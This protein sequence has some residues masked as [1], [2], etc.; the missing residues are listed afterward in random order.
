MPSS[1]SSPQPNLQAKDGELRFSPQ[2][3]LLLV[4]TGAGA[5][6]A[7]GVLMR[8][9]HFV[10]H[11]AWP[12]GSGNLLEGAERSP[13]GRH[14]IV[15]L[16][17]GVVAGIGLRILASVFRGKSSDLE[18]AIWFHWGKLPLVQTLARAL[19]SIVIVGMGASLGRESALKQVGAAIGSWLSGRLRPSPAQTRLLAACGAGAGMAAAYNMPC[20][21]ALFALEILLGELSLPLALPALLASA[22]A[23][24]VSSFFLA[25]QPTYPIP[26]Y[27]FAISQVAWALVAGPLLGLAAA[28]FVRVIS[29]AESHKPRGWGVAAAPVVVL[30]VL[31]SLS[32]P[33]PHLLGNGM[34]TVELAFTDQVGFELLLIL[35]LLKLLAT[36]SCLASGIP[37]GLFTPVLMY[38]SLLGGLLGYGYRLFWPEAPL[39]SYAILGAGAV[40]AASTQAPLSAV[41]MLTEL[42]WRLDPLM[43]PLIISVG[44]ATLVARRFELRTIY[45]IRA[46]TDEAAREPQE[47]ITPTRT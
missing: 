38:G 46:H 41:V 12:Y 17:A 34:D 36:S 32:I 35:P 25:D 11:L 23:T 37:G 18:G 16:I 44:G 30:I 19:L 27:R 31:G 1:P 22:I 15:M 13:P 5:G 2:F 8:L 3:W 7:G 4:L 45:S 14:V 28:L 39:G 10:E 9:L 43:I 24:T 33:Y 42:T 20:G 29:W 26:D 6:L 21:G 47:V 40:L